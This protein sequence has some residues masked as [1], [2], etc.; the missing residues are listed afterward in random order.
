[1]PPKPYGRGTN[2]EVGGGI[3]WDNYKPNI[4]QSAPLTA[5]DGG[6][7]LCHFVTSPHTVGSN[8]LGKGALKFTEIC[9]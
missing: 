8:P 5:A 6:G 9:V 2:R 4:P 7:P 1:M 3:C